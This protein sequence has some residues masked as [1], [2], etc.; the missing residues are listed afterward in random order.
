MEDPSQDNSVRVMG[1]F[2][3]DPEE[4]VEQYVERVLEYTAEYS[5][6]GWNHTRLIGKPRGM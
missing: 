3:H 4:L 5:Q 6:S 1:L 2:K